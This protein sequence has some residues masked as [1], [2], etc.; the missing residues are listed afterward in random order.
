METQNEIN[1]NENKIIAD[2]A[3]NGNDVYRVSAWTGREGKSFLDLRVYFTKDG[4]LR[5]TREGLNV[6]ARLRHEIADALLSAK[7]AAELPVPS[8]DKACETALVGTVAVSDSEQYQISKVR[9]P[10]NRIVR[11][12]YAFKGD[13]GAF[14]PS[15]KKAL[16]IFESAV[17]GIAQALRSPEAEPAQAEASAGAV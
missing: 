12:A 15:G 13:E 9:G 7:N 17:D 3:R 4:K 11:I 14:I 10:K 5:K 6:L 8:G 2:V 1:Q 16:S